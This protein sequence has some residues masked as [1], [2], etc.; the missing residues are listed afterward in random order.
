MKTFTLKTNDCQKN[1]L[2]IDVSESETL[3]RIS[4]VVANILKGK[5]KSTY[6]PHMDCGDKVVIVNAAKLKI[7]GK[8]ISQK[9]YYYHTGFPG[10]IRE[11]IMG[12]IFA[13]DPSKVIYK[14][15]LRML[16]KSKQRKALMRHL[17]I[18]NDMEH[19]HSGQKP[20]K[21]QIKEGKII[22]A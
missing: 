20:T 4:T 22:Y 14:S 21:I 19:S 16:A 18:Y 8:K 9:K 11:Q 6:T 3:G 13:K 15:I 5:H 17:Y 1:W 12:D 7:T 10:G 2:L